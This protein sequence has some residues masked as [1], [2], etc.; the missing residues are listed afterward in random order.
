[1]QQEATFRKV[2]KI[3]LLSLLAL[4]TPWI[5]RSWRILTFDFGFMAIQNFKNTWTTYYLWSDFYPLPL[6][7]V[8]SSCL[9]VIAFSSLLVVYVSR[10]TT[11]TNAVLVCVSAIAICTALTLS[12]YDAF[13]IYQGETEFIPIQTFVFFAAFA[14]FFN[15]LFLLKFLSLCKVKSQKLEK[16]IGNYHPSDFPNIAFL[17]IIPIIA[18]FFIYFPLAPIL[19]LGVISGL[20]LWH[21]TRASITAMFSIFFWALLFDL[22]LYVGVIFF[23]SDTSVISLINTDFI[24]LRISNDISLQM[25]LVAFTA[26]ITGL[27]VSFVPLRFRKLPIR[28]SLE[29]LAYGSVQYERV[30]KRIAVV[31]IVVIFLVMGL[32]FIYWRIERPG[33]VY[34]VNENHSLL[35]YDIYKGGYSI[36]WDYLKKIG[37]TY[38]SQN[39]VYKKEYAFP[40]RRGDEVKVKCGAG[41]LSL[42]GPFTEVSIKSPD[43]FYGE[44][45]YGFGGGEAVYKMRSSGT[46]RVTLSFSQLPTYLS[47][48][49]TKFSTSFTITTTKMTPIEYKIWKYT[50]IILTVPTTI[51]ATLLTIKWIRKKNP[52]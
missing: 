35:Y 42:L 9:A 44:R 40:V 38:D 11:R 6:L 1:M 43:P 50:F 19:V 20:M 12:I 15:D 8:L 17:I 23:A 5:T 29:N 39:N 41:D 2:K 47:V 51:A 34:I 27:A 31:W 18:F 16:I 37:L 13:A 30:T 32:S 26:F 4:F 49:I 3:A 33:T 46:C 25:L 45:T 22:I 52:T 28:F 24:F 48:K 7:H 14:S 36:D 10:K 21:P